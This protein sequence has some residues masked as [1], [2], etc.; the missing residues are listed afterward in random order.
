M[1]YKMCLIQYYQ[2]NIEPSILFKEHNSIHNQDNRQ[3]ECYKTQFC[4]KIIQSF[5]LTH[6]HKP[7]IFHFSIHQHFMHQKRLLKSAVNYQL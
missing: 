5:L 2:D 4:Q 7:E 6:T 1:T 3:M